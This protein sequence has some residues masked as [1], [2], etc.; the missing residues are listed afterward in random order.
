MKTLNI[1][2]GEN[3]FTVDYDPAEHMVEGVTSDQI[4]PTSLYVPDRTGKFIPL[5]K[6]LA[7]LA[8]EQCAGLEC[9]YDEHGI[10]NKAMMGVD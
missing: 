9:D 2:L 8:A 5:Q 10:W 4:D 7:D 1:G 3:S 6:V